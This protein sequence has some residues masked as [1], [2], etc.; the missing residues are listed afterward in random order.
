M[1]PRAPGRRGRGPPEALG[2]PAAFPSDMLPGGERSAEGQR[3]QER[4]RTRG[5]AAEPHPPGS[6][7]RSRRVP[8]RRLSSS[9][10]TWRLWDHRPEPLG[11]PPRRP[12]P[13]ARR[14]RTPTHAHAPRHGC[15]PRALRPQPRRDT[16]RAPGLG[17]GRK[18]AWRGL[19]A[20]ILPRGG[21][22]VGGRGRP[23]YLS[24]GAPR[25]SA[26]SSRFFPESGKAGLRGRKRK[27]GLVLGMPPRAAL[28][29]GGCRSPGRGALAAGAGGG[30][31][32]CSAKGPWGQWGRGSGFG[33]RRR[34]RPRLRVGGPPGRPSRG[35]RPDRR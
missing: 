16:R 21:S 35:R 5:P 14:G 2:S 6:P 26:F 17:A 31:R 32:G 13:G 7:P 11:R 28:G 18:C 9:P 15:T 10:P 34:A 12:R 33:A 1:R 3:S 22:D 27:R 23:Q 24:G 8:R 4:G 30:G 29:R 20:A 25:A 19:G